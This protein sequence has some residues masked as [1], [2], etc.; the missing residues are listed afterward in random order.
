MYALTKLESRLQV[1]RR[2]LFNSLLYFSRINYYLV[3]YYVHE[4]EFVLCT[5]ESARANA[6][7]AWAT[8]T[9]IL[10]PDEAWGPQPT[11]AMHCTPPTEFAGMGSA[12]RPSGAEFAA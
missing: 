8:H 4:K 3:L 6:T 1:P 2:L 9:T 7:C 11:A 5:T 12:K 10:A